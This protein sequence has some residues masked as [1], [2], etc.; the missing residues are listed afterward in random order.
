MVLVSGLMLSCERTGSPRLLWA[1]PRNSGT[2]GF[3]STAL[4]HRLRA[5]TK[6]IPCCKWFGY[7]WVPW[8]QIYPRLRCMRMA[9]RL[10]E[11]GHVKGSSN[12]RMIRILPAFKLQSGPGPVGVRYCTVTAAAAQVSQEPSRC[13]DPW[14]ARNSV[15]A[16]L[17]VGHRRSACLLNCSRLRAS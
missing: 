15:P 5:C 14:N 2:V 11:R 17:F 7:V 6:L 3:F 16:Q 1:G 8:F 9:V 4:P 10:P 13:P 12:C